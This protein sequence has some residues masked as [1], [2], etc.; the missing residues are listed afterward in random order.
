MPTAVVALLLL[1]VGSYVL[2]AG[3]AALGFLSA[4]RQSPPSAP[5]EWPTVTVHVPEAANLEQLRDA[6]RSGDYP[7]DRV[8]ILSSPSGDA[9]KGYTPEAPGEVVLRLPSRAE[10]ASGWV[11]S[12]VRHAQRDG[13]AV[14]GPTVVEHDDRFLPRLEAL[15]HLARLAWLGGTAHA[16]LPPGPGTTNRVVVAES[17]IPA[18]FNPDPEALVTRP[19]ASSFGDLLRRQAEWFGQSARSSSRFAQAAAVGLWVLH[20]ALLACCVVALAQPA[21]RQPTLLA[22]LGKM[23]ADVVLAL[24]AATHYGQRG[25]LRSLVPAVLMGVLSIPLAGLQALTGLLSPSTPADDP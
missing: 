8:N 22:L 9:P 24:P 13:R 7:M 18:A 16:G 21:W 4:R 25:L 6:L 14:M 23:G 11:Q 19:P 2:L 15:Q 1:L 17:D 3:A 20:A 10:V 5:A 12:M